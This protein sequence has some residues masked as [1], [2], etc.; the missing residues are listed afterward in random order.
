LTR[1]VCEALPGALPQR[2][3]GE[4]LGA[5]L[6]PAE[7]S[8]GTHGEGCPPTLVATRAGA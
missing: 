1:S 2:K 6:A 4:V 5:A 3:G 7:G 8:E